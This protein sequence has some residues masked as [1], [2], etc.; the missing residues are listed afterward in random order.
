MKRALIVSG[1]LLLTACATGKKDKA[2]S[3]DDVAD[4]GPKSTLE[5]GTTVCIAELVGV[6]YAVEDELAAQ[7]LAPEDSCMSA[8]VQIEEKGEPSDWTMRYQ[9]IGDAKWQECKSDVSV[10]E[11]FVASCI[12]QMRADLGGS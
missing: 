10:R 12:S 11:D 5:A 4:T 1:L 6:R 8:D 3:A 9:R 7:E 2:D